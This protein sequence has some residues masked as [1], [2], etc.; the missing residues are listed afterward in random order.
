MNEQDDL[1][2]V[3]RTLEGDRLSFSKLIGKYNGPV[4]SV[5][6]RMTR[7][8][9]DATDITQ[10]VF[11]RSFEKLRTF[12]QSGKFFSW[13]YRIAINESLDVL[14]HRK[15]H[16]ELDNSVESS[17]PTPEEL[18]DSNHEEER[19]ERALLKLSADYRSVV[20]LKHL[21]GL[22]YG[23]IGE[24]LSISEKKV[25]SRLFSARQLLREVLVG[26]R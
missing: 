25:K 2:L 6:Y 14:E 1:D 24:I 23:E 4:Y 9:D 26:R 20:V 13:L 16:E 19:L 8:H 15:K 10:E 18:A 22:S 21:Q 11:L 7:S 5:A 12:D 17:E 3:R